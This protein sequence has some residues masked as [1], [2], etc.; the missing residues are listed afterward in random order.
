M[1]AQTLSSPFAK[2]TN[3][4][5]FKT[6]ELDSTRF[7]AFYRQQAGTTGIYAVVGNTNANGTITWGAPLIMYTVDWYNENFDA[8]SSTPT[9]F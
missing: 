7:I 5:V 3:N 8:V 6:I 1:E 9:R 2:S 4:R